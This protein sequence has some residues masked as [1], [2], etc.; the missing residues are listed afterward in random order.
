MKA[1]ANLNGDDSFTL[2]QD[3]N[4]VYGMVSYSGSDRVCSP[5]RA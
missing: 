4:A 3:G 2:T 1:G 5:A